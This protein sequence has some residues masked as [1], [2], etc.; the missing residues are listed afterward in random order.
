MG[1]LKDHHKLIII[2]FIAFAVRFYHLSDVPPGIWLDESSIG[3]NAF[4]LS[5]TGQDEHGFFRPLFFKAFG[6]YKNPIYIYLTSFLIRL[7]GLSILTT[8][9]MAVIFGVATVL[10]TYFVGKLFIKQNTYWIPALLLACS[11]YHIIFSRIAYELISLPVLICLG[12]IF[13]YKEDKP[14]QN[15]IYA[16]IAFGLT[17]Y[18]YAIAKLLTPILV[19]AVIIFKRNGRGQRE[20]RRHLL[21]IVCAVLIAAP[22][23]VFSLRGPGMARYQQISIFNH[24]HQAYQVSLSK[25]D[26]FIRK[27]ADKPLIVVPVLFAKNVMAHAS[28]KYLF[29]E[30]GHCIRHNISGYGIESRFHIPAFLIGLIWLFRRREYVLLVWFFA[31]FIP[32]SLALVDIPSETKSIGLVPVLQIIIAV[33]YATLFEGIKTIFKSRKFVDLIHHEFMILLVLEMLILWP[34]MTAYFTSNT[35]TSAVAFDAQWREIV[36][37]T[38]KILASGD[39]VTIS[40]TFSVYYI[41]ILFHAQRKPAVY[42]RDGLGG[43]HFSRVSEEWCEKEGMFFIGAPGEIPSCLKIVKRYR[44]PCMSEFVEH[45]LEWNILQSEKDLILKYFPDPESNVVMVLARS[46]GNA[47]KNRISQEQF[48]GDPAFDKP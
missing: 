46:S 9:F 34:F 25:P 22:G 48:T 24:R 12:L 13:V 45:L 35:R 43:Y 21:T 16:G 38:E 36:E 17:I 1:F 11:Q 39:E 27:N 44:V 29:L 30:G 2:L 23:I 19:S 4:S 3:Y 47:F 41:Q 32:P 42:L 5:Q 20:I 33:G 6:E 37:D 26:S 40:E 8:R 14:Y 28:F 10:L 15:A 18:S 31:A 7:F